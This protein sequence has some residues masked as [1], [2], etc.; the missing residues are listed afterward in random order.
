MI[1][2]SLSKNIKKKKDH[3]EGELRGF[4][5]C[6][7]WETDNHSLLNLILLIYGGCLIHY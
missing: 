4:H 2:V 3:S 6:F 1:N 7:H 5:H